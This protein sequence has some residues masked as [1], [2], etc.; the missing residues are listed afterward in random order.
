MIGTADHSTARHSVGFGAQRKSDPSMRT[1]AAILKLSK[2]QKLTGSREAC[3][4]GMQ[5][6]HFWTLPWWLRIYR[7]WK[8]L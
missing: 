4:L 2:L 3:Q 8:G 7:A 1:E 5:A 6:L